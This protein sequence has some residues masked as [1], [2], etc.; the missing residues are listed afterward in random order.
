MKRLMNRLMLSC[1]K[2]SELLEKRLHAKLSM[3]EKFQLILH[4][5]MCD[6]CKTYKKQ[7]QLMHDLLVRYSRP[8]DSKASFKPLPGDIK[9]KILN[10][11]NNH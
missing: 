1:K 7:S 9:V 10:E 2:S 3:L 11:L 8:D 6:A 5:T 4:L